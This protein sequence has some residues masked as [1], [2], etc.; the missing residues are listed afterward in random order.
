MAEPTEFWAGRCLA[1]SFAS[2]YEA[3]SASDIL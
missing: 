2:R 3:A 1:A